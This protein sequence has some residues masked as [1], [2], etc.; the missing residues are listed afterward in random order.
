MQL[1]HLI[2]GC[3]WSYWMLTW[4]SL[5]CRFVL[6][7]QACLDCFICVTQRAD[8]AC[9]LYRVGKGLFSFGRVLVRGF[10]HCAC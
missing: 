4:N 10:P 1:L 2:A 7:A 9:S 5:T 6:G 3:C 8:L